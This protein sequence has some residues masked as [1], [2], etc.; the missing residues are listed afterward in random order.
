[1]NE[2]LFQI[3]KNL[4]NSS[5]NNQYIFIDFDTKFIYED[6]L[7][8]QVI[9]MNNLLRNKIIEILQEKE[10]NGKNMAQIKMDNEVIGW[11]EVSAEALIRLYRLP[12]IN[13][14]LIDNLN[15]D[16]TFNNIS[17][18]NDINN[19]KER[20]I[21]AYYMFY[22][23]NDKYIIVGRLDGLKKV[24]IKIDYFNKMIFPEDELTTYLTQGTALYNSSNYSNK[25]TEITSDSNYKVIAYLN[26]QNEARIDLEGKRYWVKTEEVFPKEQTFAHDLETLEVVDFIT[27]LFENNKVNED[28]IKVF[29]NKLNKIRKSIVYNNTTKEVLLKDKPGDIYDY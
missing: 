23:N 21:K 8:K 3:K 29:D 13:G 15:T 28:K 6:F 27:Y 18:G 2:N 22:Y 11:T 14:K 12:K 4:K 17:Y 25:I 20:I 1:M 26:N 19:I 24:P 9:G 7:M 16:Y 5:L 10:V